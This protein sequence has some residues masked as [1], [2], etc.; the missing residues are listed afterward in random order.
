VCGAVENLDGE[1]VDAR[2]GPPFR[3][4]MARKSSP[5]S[6]F[7][8]GEHFLSIESRGSG[9]R[10][11]RAEPM[12]VW[13]E[14]PDGAPRLTPDE[15]LFL[16]RAW[17][18]R[19]VFLETDDPWFAAGIGQGILARARDYTL[20]PAVATS[21]YLCSDAREQLLG[22]IDAV[23]LVLYGVSRG[24]YARLFAVRPEPVLETV[25]SLA[26]RRRVAVEVVV[27]LVP[28]GNDSSDE[29]R[30]LSSFVAEQLGS[31]V[32][33]RFVPEETSLPDER[34]ASACAAASEAGL[35]DVGARGRET[36]P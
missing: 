29:I 31:S 5:F 20:S 26:G 22:L 3:L 19:G 34:L 21:G 28:G 32:P 12:D 33:V 23:E 4:R 9:L 27:P 18:C 25:A 2:A 11:A 14:G 36:S 8:P 16:A 7:L 17:G 1:I 30:D 24:V 13:W 15:A 10:P 35:S 6:R